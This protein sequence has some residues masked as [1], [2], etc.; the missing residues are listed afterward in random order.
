M[1]SPGSF[2]RS[3]DTLPGFTGFPSFDLWQTL[4]R[5]YHLVATLCVLF[6]FPVHQQ[7]RFCWSSKWHP[8]LP[9]EPIQATISIISTW[10]GQLDRFGESLIRLFNHQ[11]PRW[12]VYSPGRGWRLPRSWISPTPVALTAGVRVGIFTSL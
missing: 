9:E 7:R 12:R 11:P 10:E 6:Y 8:A 4:F 5:I 2:N 1:L 3:F